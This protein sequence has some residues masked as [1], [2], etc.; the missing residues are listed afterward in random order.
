MKYH[1]QYEWLPV[2][3]EAVPI[4]NNGIVIHEGI[5]DAVTAD[6]SI[7]WIAAQSAN[8]RK[9]VCKAEGDEVWITYKWDTTAASD[10][11]SLPRPVVG[12]PREFLT[13]AR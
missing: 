5:V 13:I 9:M 4:Q 8:T 12:S 1:R 6:D 10:Y 11:P 2:R 3:G 7:L